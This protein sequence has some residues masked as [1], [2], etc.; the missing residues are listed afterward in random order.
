MMDNSTNICGLA[1]SGIEAYRPTVY[2]GNQSC[3]VSLRS[4][5][6]KI[7]TAVFMSDFTKIVIWDFSEK[8][9]KVK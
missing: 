1:L 2:Y 8:K 3:P 4:E 6:Q 5:L 9:S 7:T